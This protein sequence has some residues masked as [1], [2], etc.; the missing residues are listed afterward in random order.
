MTSL[1]KLWSSLLAELVVLGITNEE[2]LLGGGEID[3]AE[4]TDDRRRLDSDGTLDPFWRA[5][6][7][8]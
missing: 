2:R 5:Y 1:T 6:F 3:M 7:S 4:Q 8:F